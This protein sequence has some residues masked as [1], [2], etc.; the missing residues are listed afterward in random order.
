M[1]Q[2]LLVVA[3]IFAFSSNVAFTESISDDPGIDNPNNP[4]TTPTSPDDGRDHDHH[5]DNPG[6]GRPGG[7]DIDNPDYDGG[8]DDG[9]IDD[10]SVPGDSD[11]G[12]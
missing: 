1:K 5:T 8:G 7:T 12:I 4:G 3:A 10:P 9:D 11:W 6:D 2:F